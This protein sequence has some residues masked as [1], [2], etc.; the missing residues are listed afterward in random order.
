MAKIII[1]GS[2]N[3]IPT[4]EGENTHLAILTKSHTILVDCGANPVVRLEQAGIDYNTLTDII[5]T[6]FHPDHV[7]GLPLLLMDMWLAG[8]RK[9]IT[10]YGL[11]FTLD[12]AEA[13]M[14]LY[15]WADWPNFFPVNFCRVPA[16]ELSIIM[17]NPEVRILCSPVKHFLPNIGLRFEF[18]SED[19]TAAYSCDTEPCQTLLPLAS[20]V[21]VLLHESAGAETGHSSAAQAAEVARQ[22]EV[23]ALYLIHY[24]TGKFSRQGLIDEAKTKFPGPVFLARDFMTIDL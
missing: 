8:R 22:A 1:L 3:A 14:G 24:P 23:G 15:D 7:S 5:L 17:E 12:R 18:L 16:D 10:I 21:D 9:P 6:H 13:M 4:V 2:S 20:G 11:H 19:K